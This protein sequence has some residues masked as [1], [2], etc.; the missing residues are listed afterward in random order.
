V[1]KV[2]ELDFN[3]DQ[4]YNVDESGLFWRVLPNETLVPRNEDTAPGRKISKERVAFMTCANSTGTH[5]M[6]LLPLGKSQNQWA[7]K[8][9]SLPVIYKG[10]KK[11]RG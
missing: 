2:E 4:I 7:L 9:C 5:G 8:N 11:E 6:K 10:K 3:P 1:D